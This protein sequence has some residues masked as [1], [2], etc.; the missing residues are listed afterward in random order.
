MAGPDFDVERGLLATGSGFVA[1]VDEAGR[2]PLAGPVA[3]AA[4]IL[5]P[6]DI[7]ARLDDSKK[8][9]ARARETLF[10]IILARALAVGIGFGSLAE[11]ERLNI[12]EASLLAMRRAI[13]ALAIRPGHALIDGNALPRAMPCA[14]SAIIRGDARCVSIAAASIVAK[15]ARDRLMGRL[16]LAHPQYGWATNAGYGS[17]AHLAAL[18]QHGP[19]D[20]HRAGFAPVRAVLLTQR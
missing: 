18:V 12:R 1:G 13:D 2:G 3:A 8:L 17:A 14:A 6:Q 9:P 16:H 4:V 11:I 20:C 19:T 7:P 15:V 10:D 5:D